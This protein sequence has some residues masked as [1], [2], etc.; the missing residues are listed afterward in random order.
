MIAR[1]V[2]DNMPDRNMYKIILLKKQMILTMIG[3]Y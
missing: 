3:K 1:L 2:L